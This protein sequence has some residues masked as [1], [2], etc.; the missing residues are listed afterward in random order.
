VPLAIAKK[1]GQARRK[2]IIIKITGKSHCRLTGK[3]LRALE[4]LI[5]V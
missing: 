5:R 3:D 2:W 4:I 1:E